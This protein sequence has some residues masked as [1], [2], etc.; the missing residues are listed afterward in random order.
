M[1][2]FT[3]VL[4]FLL[5]KASVKAQIPDSTAIPPDS[6][7]FQKPD[8]LL[9]PDSLLKQDT[10]PK[11]E[12]T[13]P[14]KS[15]HYKYGDLLNDD[16]VYNRKSSWLVPLV[17]GL[18]SN[19][20]VWA[21]DRYL[22][23]YDWPATSTQDWKNNFKRGPEWDPDG[24]GVNFIGHPYA[25]NFYFNAARSNGYSYIGSFPYAVLGSLTWEYLGEKMR[26]SYN[27]MINTPIS[28]SFLGEVTY[29]LSS[30]ILDDR[31]TGANRVWR[32]ILAGLINPTRAINR[33]TQGRM[34]RVTPS[35]VYQ[36]EPVNVTLSAGIHKVND[37]VGQNND[38]GT[39]QTNYILNTQIDYGD[40]FE[41]RRRKPFDLFRLRVELSYGED[42]NLLD[43]VNG[44]GILAGKVIK[45]D[46]LLAG[47]F[48]HYDYWHNN[49]FEV[50]TLGFGGGWI[51]KI[52]I[53]QN[54]T[55]YSTI[56][57]AV[58][59]LAGNN[60]QQGPVDSKF[61]QYNYGGGLQAK[62]EETINIGKWARLG[63]TGF[64]YWIHTYNGQP[65]NSLVGI[66]KPSIALRLF[67]SLSLGFEQHI[68]RNDRWL[69]EVPTLHLTRT[70]QKL[71][72]QLFFEDDRRRG[73][74]R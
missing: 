29:R 18:A 28:G 19:A 13:L 42:R 27:D 24:F 33:L 61:R 17:R 73:K 1:K 62:V 41:T 68:Y 37:K 65:G 11:P 57:V 74:Y 12:I 67:K 2:T 44:Y 60:T 72:L 34:W 49:I 20:F 50:A 66:L 51:G 40:P 16:P 69:N 58:V 4:C 63:L 32:E 53:S 54:S 5:L 26:P 14:V 55:M 71:F 25:G 10:V 30:N 6:A 43:H 47:L 39:G 59:P 38:F 35:E 8:S 52:P 46:R 15:L 64:Y 45:E 22:F 9:T 36:K 48:Q 56:H 3:V 70:E 7:F 23:K 31:A 21:M